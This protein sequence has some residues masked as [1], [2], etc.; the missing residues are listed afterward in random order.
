MK[1]ELYITSALLKI[2]RSLNAVFE[3][4][5]IS[6]IIM[7]MNKLLVSENLDF[8]IQQTTYEYKMHEMK[9]FLIFEKHKD[10]YEDISADNIYMRMIKPIEDMNFQGYRPDKVT[11]DEQYTVETYDIRLKPIAILYHMLGYAE[12]D[13]AGKQFI[14]KVGEKDETNS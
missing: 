1:E 2:F 4:E 5:E 12:L 3:P 8:I 9:K 14:F 13:E 7:Y 6:R 10:E 11:E